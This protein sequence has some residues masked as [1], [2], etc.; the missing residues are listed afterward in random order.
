MNQTVNVNNRIFSNTPYNLLNQ[1]KNIIHLMKDH[2]HLLIYEA[3]IGH[4]KNH[5]MNLY[6]S[7][8]FAHYFVKETKSISLINKL[9]YIFRQHSSENQAVTVI[10]DAFFIKS[11]MNLAK[12]M[13]NILSQ[14]GYFT[15]SHKWMIIPNTDC[16]HFLIECT[17]FYHVICI[18]QTSKYSDIVS[19]CNVATEVKSI[20]TLEFVENKSSMKSIAF[21]NDDITIDKLF[22]NVAYKL[23]GRP[24]R[25]GWVPY[26]PYL[27][28]FNV[29][30]NVTKAV[31]G[32]SEYMEL[33]AEL[34]NMT[35][36][37][38]YP[39]DR[40]WGHIDA[41]G[42]WTG[43][44]KQLMDGE[45]DFV[46][47]PFSVS[48]VRRQVIDYSDYPIGTSYVTGIYRKPQSTSTI[49]NLIL[50]PFKLRVWLAFLIS[51]A[52]YSVIFCVA[53]FYYGETNNVTKLYPEYIKNLCF[54]ISGFL[55]QVIPMK[56]IE[57]IPIKL[58]WLFW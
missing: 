50:S 40:H 27:Y 37:I 47:A 51:I 49:L 19:L 13:D 48:N 26:G 22:P 9:K 21:K 3:T 11:V 43:M 23:N 7:I 32:Y 18:D 20:K 16:N 57:K 10:G 8:T 46:V 17:P 5:F 1:T 35:Y 34:L 39:S 14:H 45:V 54:T 33:M 25:I 6:E 52:V 24:F 55:G 56:Y 4:C 31:G 42:S 44:V 2:K 58:L 41:N 36:T 30:S 38:H 53:Q 15:Y 28:M 12:D 29:K